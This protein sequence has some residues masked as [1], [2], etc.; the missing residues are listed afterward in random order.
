MD[1]GHAGIGAMLAIMTDHYYNCGLK[2]LLRMISRCCVTC[3]RFYAKTAKQL[4]GQL[5]PERLQPSTPFSHVGI[6]YAGPLWIKRGNPCKPTLLKVYVCTFIC[7]STKAIYIESYQTSLLKP[8]LLLSLALW[9]DVEFQRQY[10]QT[11][12]QTLCE[13]KISCPIST[14]C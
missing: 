13:P 11:I 10:Y 7:F 9:P 4:M 6:D 12:G 2:S 14:P 3:Q 8:S 1:Y 5:P